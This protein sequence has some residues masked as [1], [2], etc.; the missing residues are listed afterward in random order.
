MP[1]YSPRLVPVELLAAPSLA[2][3]G[4]ATRRL[5]VAL[6]H[7]P[8]NTKPRRLCTMR[9]LALTCRPEIARPLPTGAGRPQRRLP[10]H[11]GAIHLLAAGRVTRLTGAASLLK[12]SSSDRR[13]KQI[14]KTAVESHS[15]VPHPGMRLF[16]PPDRPLSIPASGAP[17]LPQH[18]AY[19]KGRDGFPPTLMGLTLHGTHTHATDAVLEVMS[20]GTA[21]HGRYHAPM[22]TLDRLVPVRSTQPPVSMWD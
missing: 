17:G 13:T 8:P 4:E 22:S 3:L 15:E 14:G 18:P 11:P 21:V 16:T 7:G 19:S 2:S 1:K 12:T 6:C 9:A 5:T 20:P 10:S